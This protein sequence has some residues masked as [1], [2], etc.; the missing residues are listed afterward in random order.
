MSKLLE[1][2]QG[3]RALRGVVD[4]NEMDINACRPVEDPVDGTLQ[5]VK[6]STD[7]AIRLDYDGDV[8]FLKNLPWVARLN[9]AGKSAE[10]LLTPGHDPQELLK[11]LVD[12]VTVRRFD[13]REP[14]L[15]EI[16]VRTVGEEVP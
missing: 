8:S 2:R 6:S 9:D 1:V 11:A 10:V 12:R 16:F 15:H 14:S 7:Q 4:H 3:L 13:L 5:E